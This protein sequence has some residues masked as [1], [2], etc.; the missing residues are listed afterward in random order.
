M[1]Q[2]ISATLLLMTSRK[3]CGHLSGAYDDCAEQ[4]KIGLPRLMNKPDSGLIGPHRPEYYLPV[5]IFI[6]LASQ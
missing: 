4:P 5:G 3:L 6:V 2:K 1:F